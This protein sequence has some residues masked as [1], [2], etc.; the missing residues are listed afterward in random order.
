MLFK[1]IDLID[2]HL[3]DLKDM[4]VGVEGDTITYIGN[5]M[6]ADTA[7]YGRVYDGKNKI[8][9][10]G[11]YNAHGHTPMTLLRGYAE[12]HNLQDWLYHY[13][14]PFEAKITDADCYWGCML[15][16]AEMMASGTVSVSDMYG[17]M[18]ASIK[19][20]IESGFKVNLCNGLMDFDETPFSQNRNHLE[21]CNCFKL[22]H[23]AE[24]GRIKIDKSCHSVYTSN[25]KTVEELAIY[26]KQTD[27]IVQIH[28]SETQTEVQECLEKYGVT[29]VQ[30]FQDTGLLDNFVVAAHCVWLNDQDMDILA[31][32][33]V[34]AVHNCMSN[35][36]LASGVADIPKMQEK[37]IRIA[38]GTDGCSSNNNLDM[39]E[40]IKLCAVL[41]KGVRLD[42]SA[43]TTKDALAFA[44][45][46]GAFAQR[47]YD[48]GSVK[49]GNKADLIVIDADCPS[50]QP[51]YS[52]VNNVVYAANGKNVEMTMIDGKIVYEKGRFFTIDVERAIY[53]VNQAKRR[54]LGELQK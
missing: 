41:N 52:A 13:I 18:Q 9:M 36:K 37:G 17:H 29:P 48:C 33:N 24:N 20:Y 39:F 12:N 25:R 3:Q 4:Y 6:P 5:Q 1:N 44:T 38:I 43:I 54:I 10:S 47:R 45:Q 27:S 2:E 11:F 42:P 51:V 23:G 46:N 15:G 30:Y 8:L 14:F 32:N 31:K 40:E 28:L 49:V 34:V 50:M 7:R 26:A 35:L 53:E 16:I 22:Y 21:E 19:A